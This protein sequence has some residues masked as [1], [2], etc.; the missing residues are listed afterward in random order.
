MIFMDPLTALFLKPELHHFVLQIFSPLEA[1]EAAYKLVITD[2]HSDGESSH[3]GLNHMNGWWDDLEADNL[4]RCK[5]R[6]SM[7]LSSSDLNT[8]PQW[9]LQPVAKSTPLHPNSTHLWWPWHSPHAVRLKDMWRDS[10]K[11]HN[12]PTSPRQPQLFLTCSQQ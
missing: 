9:I 10:M 4:P 3:P 2:N 7:W 5:W 8:Y 11:Y 12:R 1:L 6:T